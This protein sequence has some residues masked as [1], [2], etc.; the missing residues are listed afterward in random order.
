MLRRLWETIFGA[1]TGSSWIDLDEKMRASLKLW[2]VIS[3]IVLLFI[4]LLSLYFYIQ[5][6]PVKNLV[7]RIVG[8]ILKSIQTRGEI[9]KWIITVGGLYFSALTIVTSLFFWALIDL[10]KMHYKL[11]RLTFRLIPSVQ[12]HILSKTREALGCPPNGTQCKIKMFTDD[13]TGKRRFMNDVFYHFANAEMVGQHNQKDKRKQVFGVWTQYYLF[14]YMVIVL[15]L[16]CLWIAFLVI[17]KHLL[18]GWPNLILPALFG[19]IVYCYIRRGLTF[20]RSVLELAEDQ[21][22]AFNRFARQELVNQARFVV[23]DL[24]GCRDKRCPL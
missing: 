5:L 9:P 21:V 14:N 12:Q 2:G 3:V 23:N 16:I 10:G 17:I 6:P 7:D 4:I 24:G 13:A 8:D 1:P 11:D 18:T 15:L 20:R 22:R 19:V